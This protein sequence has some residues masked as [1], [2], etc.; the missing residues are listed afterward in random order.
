M[1]V[2]VFQA[3][4]ERVT[5]QEAARHYGLEVNRAG[6]CCCPFHGEKTPSMKLFPDDRGFYCFGCHKGG[7]VI[8][9]VAGLLGLD[10]LGAVR[11]LNEDF[12]LGLEMDHKPDKRALQEA[13]RRRKTAATVEGRAPPQAK[14]P[15]SPAL[16]TVHTMDFPIGALPGPVE[17]F[18]EQ[19]AESTQTP[20]EMGGILSLGVLAAAF[21]D[22]YTV[23]I[24]PDWKKCLCLYTVAVA[25]PAERKS[26]V[27]AA[28]T[29]PLWEYER[30]R[31]EAE[32]A[33]VAQNQAK[34]AM[35][36][37]AFE[38][39]KTM[40][41]KG[42][43]E[44]KRLEALDLAAQLATFRDLHPFRLVVDDTTPE[45]LVDLMEEQGGSLT[46]AS[47]EGGLFDSIAGRYDR[48][49]NFDIYLK[50]HDGEPITVDR[51]GRKANSIKSARLSMI[52][53]VQPQVLQGLMGNGIFHG[54]GL[55]GRFLYAI[56]KSKVGQRNVSPP[57]MTDK[58]K[59]DYD[60][61]VRRILSDKGSGVVRLS[62]E[63][64]AVREAYQEYVEKK[65]GPDGDWWFMGDWGGKLTGAMVRIAALLHLSSFP[66][67]VPINGET[68]TAAVSIAEFLASHEE[69]AYQ[70]M[71][72]DDGLSDAKY[73]WKKIYAT[74]RDE[75][76]KRD[77]FQFVRGKLCDMES[78]ERP[79]SQLEEYGYIRVCEVPATGKGRKP[80]PI[81]KVNPLV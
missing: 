31:R 20:E 45:K 10:P 11:Q 8:D 18:V 15:E 50:G 22:R 34:R 54:R 14:E 7:S 70:A 47:A 37:R 25:P 67:A 39:A 38:S 53:T 5:A 65:L 24:T 63:A 71:G 77:L 79:L 73:L 75:I 58:A 40:A 3:V 13:D 64:D 21:Q 23:E 30:E 60:R 17:A 51:I 49:A 16:D 12:R 29:R 78:M 42:G 19:L 9:L 56:C 57:P 66:A 80:S 26:A 76:S 32:A 69:A 44:D 36:E 55:C 59:Q 27:I 46:V 43:N 6:F 74:G 28:L 48:A 4:R 1:T 35:M 41:A 62:P 52:L 33:E 61:F 72:G 68:M 81:L 2:D